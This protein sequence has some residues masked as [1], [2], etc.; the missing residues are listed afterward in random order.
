MSK[1]ITCT[2]DRLKS[3]KSLFE[4]YGLYNFRSG[5]GGTDIEP[6]NEEFNTPIIG[7]I[8]D[9]QRYFDYHHS[10]LDTFDKVN[11]REVELGAG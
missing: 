4:P 7:L 8:N 3:W 5:G 6:L 2:K 9:T 10:D 11:K 1:R